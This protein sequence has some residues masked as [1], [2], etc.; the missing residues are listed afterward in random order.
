MT[1]VDLSNLRVLIAEDNTHMRRI[2]RSLLNAFGI[3]EVIEAED[4]A[5]ALELYNAHTPDLLITD[6]A[7]PII[8]GLEL[9]RLIRNPNSKA[10]PYIPIIV[11]TGHAERKRVI[12]ARDAGVTEFLAKPISAKALYTRLA[13]TVTHPRSF[14]RTKTYFGPDR[15]RYDNPNYNGPERRADRMTEVESNQA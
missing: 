2:V 3:R 11:L 1:R 13:G 8:D 5:N 10:N 7:M 15:R 12:E 4:G 14:V 9:T 6:W